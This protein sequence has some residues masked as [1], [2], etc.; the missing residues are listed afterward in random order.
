MRLVFQNLPLSFFRSDGAGT[1]S[2]VSQCST[3]LPSATLVFDDGA[4]ARHGLQLR[5]QCVDPV[6]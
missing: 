6:L 3:S 5:L 4:V 2:I 1:A